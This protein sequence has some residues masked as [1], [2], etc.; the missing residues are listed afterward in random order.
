MIYILGI[1]NNDH[2]SL[3]LNLLQLKYKIISNDELKYLIMD[4]LGLYFY[5]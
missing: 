4:Q 1:E 3:V 5:N 2:I